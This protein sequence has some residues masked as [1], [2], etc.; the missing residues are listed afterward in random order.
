MSD[1]NKVKELIAQKNFKAAEA[2]L[3]SIIDPKQLSSASYLETVFTAYTMMSD[4]A[5][6][7]SKYLKIDKVPPAPL[8]TSYDIGRRFFYFLY[9]LNHSGGMRIVRPYIKDIKL[10][11]PIEYQ[12]LGGIYF[13]N[14]QYKEARELYQKAAKELTGEFDGIKHAPI[15]TN[16]GA[17]SLY[18]EDYDTLEEVKQTALERS[19]NHPRVIKSFSKYEILKYAQLGNPKSANELLEKYRADGSI[20]EPTHWTDQGFYLFMD[21]ATG[22]NTSDEFS[23]KLQRLLSIW[24]EDVQK[25]HKTPEQYLSMCVYLSKLTVHKRDLLDD[26]F[27]SERTT[28]PFLDFGCLGEFISP[29]KFTSMGNRESENFINYHTGEYSLNGKKGI[30]LSSELKA[31]YWLVRS[32]EFGISFETLASLIYEED[33]FAGLFLIKKRVKLG[34]SP[35][36]KSLRPRYYK[37]KLSRLFIKR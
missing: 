34:N 30:G 17:C 1:F 21:V 3:K 25:G 18:M 22:E 31:T 15:L 19:S 23:I 11:R 35:A 24:M 6:N 5:R 13:Y 12:Y 4:L 37:Q 9:I 29:K 36:Q 20:G 16:V 27:L 14:H 32:H 26:L 28:Y 2:L 8:D 7:F 33:D 10:N